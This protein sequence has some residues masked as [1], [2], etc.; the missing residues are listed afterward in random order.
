M[1][2]IFFF[3]VFDSKVVHH[4]AKD[5]VTG[6]MFEETGSVWALVVIILTEVG[7]ELVLGEE[8]GVGKSVH[9]FSHC[10]HGAAVAEFDVV[11]DFGGE[12]NIFFKDVHEFR[13]F[14]GSAKVV[15]LDVTCAPVGIFGYH[16]IE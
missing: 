16:G 3:F 2:P 10:D 13:I 1:I 9:S 14:H 5:D 11:F 8:T 4:E 12:W 7:D 15:V 6:G